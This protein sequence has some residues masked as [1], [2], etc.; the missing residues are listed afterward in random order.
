MDKNISSSNWIKILMA[1][2]IGNFV[3]WYTFL[4][5]ASLSI[6]ISKNF[7]PQM[8]NKTSNILTLLLYAVGFLARPL[9]AIIFGYCG[10]YF[11]RQKSLIVSQFLMCVATFIISILPTTNQIGIYAPILLAS[12][13]FLQ[14]ISIAGEYSNSLCYLVEI[15]PI[16]KRGLY[17]STI[18]ASTA[19][20]ILCS[21]ITILIIIRVLDEHNLFLWGWRVCFFIGFILCSIGLLIRMKL[22]ESHVYLKTNN[23]L[24]KQHL[25]KTLTSASNI[26]SMSCVSILVVIYAYFYQLL[27]IWFPIFLIK[28]FNI[29][30]QLSLII[31]SFAMLIFTISIINSGKLADMFNRKIIIQLSLIIIAITFVPAFKYLVIM[32][33]FYFTIIFTVFY[34]IIF[35][36]FVGSSSTFFAE[37]FNSNIRATSLS[38]SYNLPYAF[39]GGL[40]PVFLESIYQNGDYQKIAIITSSAMLF[41]FFLS[42]Y[43]VDHTGLEI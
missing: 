36:Y 42:L 25:F 28:E 19:L 10:D 6:V 22:P 41:C 11:G 37:I 1:N 13:R 35:G 39:I 29:T 31:N 14:G 30:H 27:Y 15:A 40:T 5:Y 4:A 33:I 21:S 3:E 7:F 9:G 23:S 26:K 2:S 34:S 16:K 12:M 43:I 17:I 32:H 24:T 38:L 18:P 20:G 8:A